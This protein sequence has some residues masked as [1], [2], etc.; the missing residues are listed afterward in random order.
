MKQVILTGII[1]VFL[2]S[3]CA[4]NS[5]NTQKS[6]AKSGLSETA[7]GLNTKGTVLGAVS[8]DLSNKM[9]DEQESEMR[10]AMASSESAVIKREGNILIITLKTDAD[11]SQILT[12]H[13][14]DHLDEFDEIARIMI[15]YPK[16]AIVVEGH[17][18]NVGSDTYNLFL[19]KRRASTI[20]YLL[21]QRGV[22][23][24]RINVVGYGE[25]RPLSTNTTVD[26]RQMNR[27][28]DLLIQPKS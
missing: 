1:V 19:S 23:T 20:K 13:K 22:S 24:H 25:S 3:G 8:I 27:R 17:T 7:I 18:D 5:T 21:V 11:F 6:S 9:M 26:G 14:P 28:V 10:D 15:K 16:T 4:T 2:I 12:N